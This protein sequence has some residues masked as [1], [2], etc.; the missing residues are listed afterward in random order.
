[1]DEFSIDEIT[2]TIKNIKEE[3]VTK[4]EMESELS[5]LRTLVLDRKKDSVLIHSKSQNGK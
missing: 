5:K 2:E 4:S 1:M 3:L